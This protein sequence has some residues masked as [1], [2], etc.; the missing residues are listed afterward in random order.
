VPGFSWLALACRNLCREMLTPTIPQCADDGRYSATETA[1]L[2]GIH[3]NTLERY[4]KANLIKAGF[5]RTT[6]RKFYLGSEIK[7]LWRML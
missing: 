5:R 1:A 2:L 4:R 6:A 3:R 7:R